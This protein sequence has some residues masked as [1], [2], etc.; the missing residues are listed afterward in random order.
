MD[1][2]DVLDSLIISME[3]ACSFG[4]SCEIAGVNYLVEVIHHLIGELQGELGDGR[5]VVEQVSCFIGQG[6]KLGNESIDFSWSEAKMTEFFLSALRG[7]SVLEG[8][9]ECSSDSV[10]IMFI[11]YETTCGLL[12]YGYDS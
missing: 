8:C 5:P 3:L 11:C 6:F 12:L 9:F 4:P 10:P 2:F 1:V 7:A